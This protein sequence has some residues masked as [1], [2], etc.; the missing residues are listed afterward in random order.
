MTTVAQEPRV[1]YWEELSEV[2]SA[3]ASNFTK[4]LRHPGKVY[5]NAV[6]GGQ[7]WGTKYTIT[8][9]PEL[10]VRDDWAR[11]ERVDPYLAQNLLINLA[12]EFPEFAKINDWRELTRENITE[13]LV[14]RLTMVAHRRTFKGADE[15][16]QAWVNNTTGS[17][18]VESV[19]NTWEIMEKFL[20][21]KKAA[22]RRDESIQSYRNTLRPFA[23]NF[24]TL[25]AK[26]EQIEEYLLPHRGEN[27]T[28]WNIFT[29]IRLL[30][31]FAEKRGLLPFPNP[32]SQM[33]APKKVT[34]PPQ[35]LSFSQ[36]RA[37]LK[38]IRDVVERGLVY[39]LFG[40]GLRLGEVRRLTPM[41]IGEDTIRTIHGKE[42]DEP[43]PLAP[44]IREVLL[45]LAEGKRPDEPIFQGRQGPLSDSRIQD[46][47]KQL[48][49]RAGIAGVQQSPH[50]LRHSKGVLG[51]MLGLDTYSNRRLLRHTTTQMSDRYN[52]LNLEE[53]KVKDRQYNPLLRILAEPELGKKPDCTQCQPDVDIAFPA[54]EPDAEAEQ[55]ASHDT[56]VKTRNS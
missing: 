10:S 4:L 34:K 25:P 48:F 31:N 37:L 18:T 52:E 43:A 3:L 12:A 27:S 13:G 54:K 39:C 35:H 49:I 8:V 44:T 23:R 9:N 5:G 11:L 47:I 7:L 46:I 28:A 40:L 45:K 55:D 36:A 30:Y 19:V 26:P 2:A 1:K 33:E 15:V 16:S 24:P 29:R 38:A 17:S 50:T 20:A 21:S 14:E 22:N 42:R 41:D 53:L 6:D 51:N 56:E 32:M